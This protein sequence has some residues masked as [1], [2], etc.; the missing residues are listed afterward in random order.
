[1]KN[2]LP[3]FIILTHIVWEVLSGFTRHAF[4]YVCAKSSNV[5]IF[6][7]S[8]ARGIRVA[9]DH[10]HFTIHRFR[11]LN[12]VPD[13]FTWVRVNWSLNIASEIILGRNDDGEMYYTEKKVGRVSTFVPDYSKTSIA[14]RHWKVPTVEEIFG[15][16]QYNH[17]EERSFHL[18]PKPLTFSSKFFVPKG[19]TIRECKKWIL[20]VPG[21]FYFI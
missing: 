16:P 6:A 9:F 2:V 13:F 1:M 12:S 18:G 14:C 11:I 4:G 20:Y 17:E 3:T 21:Y 7:Y 19:K 8:L 10:E 5:D 15:K